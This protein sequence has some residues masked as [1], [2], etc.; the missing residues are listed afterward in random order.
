MCKEVSHVSYDLGTSS[1]LT[2]I[3]LCILEQILKQS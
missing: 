1:C 3:D 2:R